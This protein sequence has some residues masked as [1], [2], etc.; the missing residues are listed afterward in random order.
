MS[1]PA[2]IFDF[3][4]VLFRWNPAELL[5]LVL[6][7]RV[8][9]VADA[10]HWKLQFFQQYEGDW[11]AFDSGL[12]DDAEVVRRIAV[13]TGLTEAEVR[14]VVDAVPGYLVP[15][16]GTVAV[17]RALK[18]AGHPLFF[19]SNMPA[20]Y[21]EYLRRTHDFLGWFEAGVFSSEVKMGKPA[22]EVFELALARFGLQPGQALFIDDH[23][24]NISAAHAL[25]LPAVLFTS[26]EQLALDLKAQG[27]L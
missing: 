19:L 11:G 3:G 2:V 12:I 20:P 6:P 26:A 9:N 8:R 24:I 5:A 1:K 21:A 14:A 16:P 17:L 27:L 25:G 23:P 4:G 22:A 13:R 10:E 7:D 18:D 15:Q